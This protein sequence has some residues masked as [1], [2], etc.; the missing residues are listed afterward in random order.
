MVCPLRTHEMLAEGF[1]V[2]VHVN[3]RQNVLENIH[4]AFN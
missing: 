3:L 1:D 4:L 2:T